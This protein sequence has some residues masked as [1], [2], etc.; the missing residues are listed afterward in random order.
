MKEMI[1]I[2]ILL[3]VFFS[4]LA[5][6]WYKG[7]KALVKEI[8]LRAMTIAEIVLGSKKGQEK[9]GIVLDQ[10]V[11]KIST[12]GRISGWLA[13]IIFTKE[14]LKKMIETFV[15][16]INSQFSTVKE[17]HNDEIEEKV[18]AAVNFGITK[19]T[20]LLINESKNFDVGGVKELTHE[21]QL[22]GIAEKLN[23][24]AKDKG[25]VGAYAEFKTDFEKEKELRAGIMA[26]IKI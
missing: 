5:A 7:K 25:F 18:K 13:S 22:L 17:I 19:G 1:G 4:I 2:L 10:T 8:L 14:N 16:K 21:S 23:L 24:E 26:G 9:L 20:E 3:A 12:W 11:Y 15:P 6:L